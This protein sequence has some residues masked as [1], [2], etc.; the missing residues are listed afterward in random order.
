MLVFL[1]LS[2]PYPSRSQTTEKYED[3]Y[4]EQATL[5]K[6]A[7]NHE[8]ILSPEGGRLEEQASLGRLWASLP[9]LTWADQT[10]SAVSRLILRRAQQLGTTSAPTLL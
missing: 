9:K 8:I 6:R 5:K 1:Q 10:V 2:N 4:Q 3:A 7:N